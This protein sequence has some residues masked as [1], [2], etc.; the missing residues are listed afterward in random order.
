LAMPESENAIPAQTAVS[1][2]MKSAKFLPC[3][4]V[5]AITA[6]LDSRL[7]FLK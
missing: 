1:P 4:F 7:G 3:D 6:L 5:A 2:A